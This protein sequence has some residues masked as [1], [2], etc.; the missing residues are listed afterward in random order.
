MPHHP[1]WSGV[2]L[3]IGGFCASYLVQFAQVKM[4]HREV[5]LFARPSSPCSGVL[6][7]APEN[8]ADT[9]VPIPHLHLA[10]A[11][12]TTD[13]QWDRHLV[14]QAEQLLHYQ[15]EVDILLY[16]GVGTTLAEHG[17][18]F[19][20]VRMEEI[21]RNLRR[22]STSDGD[23]MFLGAVLHANAT[24]HGFDWLL[25]GESVTTFFLDSVALS[26]EPYDPSDKHFFG[27]NIDHAQ[28]KKPTVSR[29]FPKILAGC[30]RLGTPDDLRLVSYYNAKDLDYTTV[31]ADCNATEFKNISLLK[32]GWPSA[33]FG[34]IL[35][36][37]L[38]DGISAQDWQ[39]CVDR[40]VWHGAGFRLSACVASFGV[41]TTRLYDRACSHPLCRWSEQRLP[42][43]NL[44]DYAAFQKSACYAQRAVL[45]D[46]SGKKAEDKKNTLL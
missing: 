28:L 22:D 19:S 3:F 11:L 14:T 21:P 37:G 10:A 29:S 46:K 31:H 45:C 7:A 15:S 36:R 9:G 39:K 1:L 20:T 2:I 17:E 27:R 5:D 13:P 43:R 26:L 16:T 44:K 32:W 6:V 38:L 42:P 35:S 40:L 4:S 24:K 41:P 34:S 23:H 30:P 18:P 12:V 25:V 8:V 33:Q